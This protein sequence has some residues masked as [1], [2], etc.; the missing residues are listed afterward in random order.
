MGLTESNGNAFIY[1][2]LIKVKPCSTLN[3]NR[4]N[5]MNMKVYLVIDLIQ[6]VV[7]LQNFE[8]N[9]I[10][11][12]GKGNWFEAFFY[13]SWSIF[14]FLEKLKFKFQKSISVGK[15]RIF[16]LLFFWETQS[17]K[18]TSTVQNPSSINN[19]IMYGIF[20]ILVLSF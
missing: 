3:Q 4:N 12:K 2:Y 20:T 14:L 5:V 18:K 15:D 19:T 9:N 16:F 10:N 11:K 1:F 13:F 8:R 17:I 7:F 6:I